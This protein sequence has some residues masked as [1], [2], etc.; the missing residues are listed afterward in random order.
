MTGSDSRIATVVRKLAIAAA[1][2]CAAP[3]LAACGTVHQSPPDPPKFSTV[4]HALNTDLAKMHSDLQRERGDAAAGAAGPHEPRCYNLVNNVNFAVL[5]TID[6]FAQNTVSADVTN[7][8]NDINTIRS[9]VN[10]YR[11]DLA[12]FINEGVPSPTG[13]KG[14]I[15]EISHEIGQ[16]VTQANRIIKALQAAI[17]SAYKVADRLAVQHCS[18]DKPQDQTAE[19]TIPSVH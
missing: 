1:I 8:Q 6:N 19:P 11:A 5:Q 10:S 9:D 14:E 13:S 16:V 17:S 2:L 4:I 3:V 18:S 15:K 12:D 7:L